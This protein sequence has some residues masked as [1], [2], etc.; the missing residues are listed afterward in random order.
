M[1]LQDENYAKFEFVKPNNFFIRS[2]RA[3]Y[4]PYF[5]QHIENYL[6]DF[7]SIA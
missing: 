1:K 2:P 4:F 6:E 3:K 7:S 5:H